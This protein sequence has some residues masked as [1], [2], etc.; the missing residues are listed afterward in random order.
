[1]TNSQNDMNSTLSF[2]IEKGISLKRNKKKLSLSS[3][4]GYHHHL[5]PHQMLSMRAKRRDTCFVANKGSKRNRFHA[6]IESNEF[7]F[8]K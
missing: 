8:V 4:G 1:M 5:Y 3:I 7:T 2:Y 6:E